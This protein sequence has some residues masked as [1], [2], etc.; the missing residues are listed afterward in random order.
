[1]LMSAKASSYSKTLVYFVQVVLV[2]GPNTSTDVWLSV[3]NFSPTTAVNMCPFPR[4]FLQSQLTQFILPLISLG[5]L[6]ISV[7]LLKL[8]GLCRG[9]RITFERWLIRPL[10]ALLIATVMPFAT[11]VITLLNCRTVYADLSPRYWVLAASPAISCY[12][13]TY[14]PY[15]VAALFLIVV[16]ALVPVALLVFLV[17]TAR[18]ANDAHRSRFGYLYESYNARLYFW[19]V[20]IMTRRILLVALAQIDQTSVRQYVLTIVCVV[21]AA[22]HML[23]AP[24]LEE[25]ANRTETFALWMLVVVAFTSSSSLLTEHLLAM[26][27]LMT[28][29]V[30]VTVLVILAVMIWQ[31]RA[32]VRALISRISR[33]KSDVDNQLTPL[34][35]SANVDM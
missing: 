5:Q 8:F 27:V 6:L 29:L 30:G 28:V 31:S 20:V 32:R 2:L 34:M 16:V 3:F 12:S 17:R 7:V 9:R 15:R 13:P 18:G 10:C 19:E 24:M 22:T 35:L 11:A 4:S 1:M 26:Q 14:W 23:A 25:A 33:K 21:I